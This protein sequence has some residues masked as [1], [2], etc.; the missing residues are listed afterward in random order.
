MTKLTLNSDH[1]EAIMSELKRR[2]DLDIKDGTIPNDRRY[3]KDELSSRMQGV[4]GTIMSIVT[5]DNWCDIV[6][7]L[8]DELEQLFEYYGIIRVKGGYTDYDE[9]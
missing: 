2:I 3:I 9:D 7:W 6:W 8:D 5:M 1:I 4:Y